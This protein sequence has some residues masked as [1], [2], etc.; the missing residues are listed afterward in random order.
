MMKVKATRL[1]DDIG[2]HPR[3]RDNLSQLYAEGERV[4]LALMRTKAHAVQRS[5]GLDYDD[6]LQETRIALM[7]AVQ[8]Y[9]SNKGPL[10]KYAGVIIDNTIRSMILD[11]EK[12]ARKECLVG[13]LGPSD[14]SDGDGQG[15]FSSPVLVDTSTPE[16]K[17][18]EAQME[19]LARNLRADLGRGLTPRDQDV[20]FARIDIESGEVAGETSV[21][22]AQQLGRNRNQVWWSLD[23][24]RKVFK[25]LAGS[26]KFS[27]LNLGCVEKGEGDQPK[28]RIKMAE[29]TAPAPQCVGTYESDKSVDGYTI[30]NGDSSGKTEAD[31][32]PCIWRNRCVGIQNHIRVNG[33][34]T[35]EF[36]PSIGREEL[37]QLGEDMI[38]QLGI[39]DGKITKATAAKT[40]KA[41]AP[42]AADEKPKAA[43]KAA[44][45]PKPKPAVKA[46]EAAPEAPKKGPKSGPGLKVSKVAAPPEEP[47]EEAAEE[48]AAEEPEE[49]TEVAEAAAEEEA[50]KAT[51]KAKPAAKPAAK[52][53]AKKAKPAEEAGEETVE[54]AG[55][56][57]TKPAKAAKEP[58]EIPEALKELYGHFTAK[59]AEQFSGRAIADGS[60]VV[61]KP[62]TLY[63]IDHLDTSRYIGWYVKMPKGR[64]KGLCL[65]YF[66]PN[67]N[68]FNFRIAASLPDVQKLV[69]KSTFKQLNARECKDGQFKTECVRMDAAGAGLV[70]EVLKK[71]VDNGTIEMPEAA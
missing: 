37:A 9:D 28:R 46:A 35:D 24:A 14:E 21:E 43:P 17:L 41:A 56:G 48:T 34:D 15:E 31:R 55:E 27:E 1:G 4:L 22:I 59:L 64:D 52:A 68:M 44:A 50:P 23:K 33:L 66:K 40:A 51:P 12:R 7:A 29:I 42:P 6:V 11:H 8:S 60:K 5:R 30:C 62:G 20:Y 57:E 26:K 13:V 36:I 61:A 3:Y 63:S 58:K 70:A 32:A 65:V 47:A 10:Y 71:L 2:S 49:A 54:A 19:K 18:S 45:A 38:M 67:L 25:K 69:G 53:V 39:K 16:D